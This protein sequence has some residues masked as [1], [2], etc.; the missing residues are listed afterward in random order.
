MSSSFVS[1]WVVAH[2]F[3]AADEDL[4][5]NGNVRD[6]VVERW[7]TKVRDDY[8]AQCL[9]LRDTAA[10]SGLALRC[11]G[12]LPAGRQFGRPSMLVVSAGVTEVH[13]ASFTLALRLRSVGQGEDDLAVNANC[14]VTLVD[15]ATGEAA[16]IDDTIR[17]EMIAL[18]HAARHYN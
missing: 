8:L 2:T 16:P 9:V 5:A 3:H 6:D 10:R 11:A 12:E 4:D 15:P 13:P 14:V 1:R 18:E 17:D 7:I